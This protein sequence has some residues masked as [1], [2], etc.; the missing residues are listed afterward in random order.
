MAGIASIRLE[1]PADNAAA[2]SFYRS[3]GFTET[4]LVPGY[5]EGHVAARRMA[6]LLRAD[7]T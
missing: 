1:L 6:L 5:H 2:L 7:A 4:Q 3:L